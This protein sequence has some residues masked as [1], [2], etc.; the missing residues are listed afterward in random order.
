MAA[1]SICGQKGFVGLL[2]FIWGRGVG[3]VVQ[4]RESPDFRSPLGSL[5]KEKE[6]TY[7]NLD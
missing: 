5:K 4:N 1:G 3:A 2:T 6:N 7:L